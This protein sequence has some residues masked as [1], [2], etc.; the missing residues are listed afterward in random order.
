[1]LRKVILFSILSILWIPIIESQFDFS[2][3]QPLKRDYLLK[4]ND[5]SFTT[6][7]W[8][9]R[10][11]QEKKDHY[12]YKSFPLRPI[13]TRIHNQ[14]DYSLFDITHA[15]KVV[16]GKNDMLLQEGYLDCYYGGDY[17]GDSL[18]RSKIESYSKVQSLLNKKGIEVFLVI[19]ADKASLYPENIPDHYI[20]E[21]K[22]T[23]Y[24]KTIEVLDSLNCNYLDLKQFL[25]E[26]K[27]ESPYPLFTNAGFHWSG[28]AVTLAADTLLSFIEDKTNLDFI[29][30]ITGDGVLTD[31]YRFTDNDL[32]LTLN[33]LFRNTH[34]K[35]YYP[36]ISFAEIKDS[37]IKPNVLL[38]GD[39]YT[40]SFWGFY[41]YF[42]KIFSDS[43]RFWYYNKRVDWPHA[44]K[45]SDLSYLDLHEEILSRDFIL[46]VTNEKHLMNPGFDFF[47]Q[48]YSILT[49]FDKLSR[50]K[51][52]MNIHNLRADSTKV[53][54]IKRQAIE[55]NIPFDSM[56]YLNARWLYS[57]YLNDY[58]R[59][60]L[61]GNTEEFSKL[62]LQ[63]SD[64][65][66]P[67]DS[68]LVTKVN[69]KVA[70]V[71]KNTRYDWFEEEYEITRMALKIRSNTKWYNRVV[72]KANYYKRKPSDQLVIEARYAI[73]NK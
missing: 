61:T 23:N 27:P 19:V 7:N 47:E 3:P 6:D 38:V 68:L 53:E 43:S 54:L 39:G 31:N 67:V 25:I 58:I 46:I 32:G 63:A 20:R 1:M 2:Q 56:L 26:E 40:Q 16:V 4:A 48:A 57:N 18:I 72:A 10:V 33:L 52:K 62:E 41:Q 59:E 22:I 51:I 35:V 64:I 14:I 73:Q 24:D 69:T 70:K 11:Y 36:E 66:V 55:R 21:M 60:E 42:N 29:D 44:Y 5:I 12:L 45:Q 49:D 28:Y 71:L 50:E 13:L 65:G 17:V 30:I 37:E 15:N 34:Q 8:F 9:T